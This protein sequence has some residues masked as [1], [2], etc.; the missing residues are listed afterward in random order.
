[1]VTTFNRKD[2]ISFGKYLLSTERRELFLN[3]PNTDKLPQSLEE[4][5]EQVH[6]SDIENWAI[7]QDSRDFRFSR[8]DMLMFAGD[9]WQCIMADKENALLGKT[10]I[11]PDGSRNTSYEDTMVVSNDPDDESFS[12]YTLVDPMTKE[13]RDVVNDLVAAAK[14]RGMK[15][16]INV[17]KIDGGWTLWHDGV[18]RFRNN[19]LFGLKAA[20]EEHED[21]AWMNHPFQDPEE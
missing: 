15:G 11:N 6:H 12:V 10:M 7:N 20:V 16:D 13:E 14:A 2:L 21:L 18:D 8:Y 19:E 5:L 9:Q 1:M 3:H 17:I 4:R